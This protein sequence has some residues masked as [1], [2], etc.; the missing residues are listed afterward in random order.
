MIK[1]RDAKEE[2]MIFVKEKIKEFK[3]DPENLQSNQFIVVEDD[4]KIVGFGRL[5]PYKDAVEVGSL[6]V[7]PEYRKKGVAKLIMSEL[8]KKGPKKLYAT[9]D[10]PEFPAKFG[11]KIIDNPPESIKHKCEICKIRKGIVAMEL[12]KE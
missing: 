1:I 12:V 8:I 5:K 3:L 6:G 4:K 2:D 11:F 9:T 7:I 10:I